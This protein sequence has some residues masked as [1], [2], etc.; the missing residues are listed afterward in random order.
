MGVFKQIAFIIYD[1]Y[2]HHDALEDSSVVKR[3]KMNGISAS[4][5]NMIYL[6]ASIWRKQSKAT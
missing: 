4:R 6:D 3:P 1:I 2:D 5:R